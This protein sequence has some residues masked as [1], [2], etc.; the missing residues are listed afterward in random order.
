MKI[1]IF[2]KGTNPEKFKIT[3]WLRKQVKTFPFKP[4]LYFEDMNDKFFI[5]PMPK[6]LGKKWCKDLKI[7]I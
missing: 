1:T 2:I 4:I 3:K 7:K 5:L 6:K